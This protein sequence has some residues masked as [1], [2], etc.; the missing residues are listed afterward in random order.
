MP[1]EKT[2]DELEKWISHQHGHWSLYVDLQMSHFPYKLPPGAPAPFQPSDPT[3]GSFTYLGYPRKDRQKAINRYDNALHYVDM[4]IGR[5]AHY[6]EQTGQLDSTLWVITADHGEMFF[7]HG[8][9]THGKTLYEGESRV[10]LLVHW[11]ERVKPADVDEPVSTLDILPTMA[12]LVGHSAASGVPGSKLPEP[13]RARR[14]AHRDLHEH[15]GPAQRG[16]H[17]VL[18]LEADRRAN[19]SPGA[20]VQPGKA[21]PAKCTIS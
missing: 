18:A 7:D 20:P 15:P 2:V 13:G 5:M 9:V 3:P 19:G 12:E 4:Q 16:R 8:M 10:P 14:G 1:D 17:R 6:L 11:P 21:I